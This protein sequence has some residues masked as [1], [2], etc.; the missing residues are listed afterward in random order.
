[1]LRHKALA[2]SLLVS[3]ACGPVHLPKN[4]ASASCSSSD[5]TSRA[6]SFL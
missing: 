6:C 3:S 5:G 2:C 1:M 4:T